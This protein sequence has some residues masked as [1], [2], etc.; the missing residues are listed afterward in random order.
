MPQ[1]FLIPS[2]RYDLNEDGRVSRAELIMML[3]HVPASIGFVSGSS[4]RGP[5]LSKQ[6]ATDLESLVDAIVERAFGLHE[7]AQEGSMDYESFCKTVVD[8]PELSILLE[9]FS[10]CTMQSQALALQLSESQSEITQKQKRM[11]LDPT[12]P[13]NSG[14]KAIRTSNRMENIKLQCRV[15]GKF[16][17]CLGYTTLIR[18]IFRHLH[19]TAT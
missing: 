13:A 6:A 9:L 14:K 11:S 15:C 3:H 7:N 10:V 12:S 8:L 19:R 1:N 18:I 2:H 16:E 4:I 17:I 5:L